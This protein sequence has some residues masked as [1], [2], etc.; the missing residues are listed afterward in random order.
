MKAGLIAASIC[1]ASVYL[2]PIARAVD[3]ATQTPAPSKVKV[4]LI[5]PE[6]SDRDFMCEAGRVQSV[7]AT[8]LADHRVVSVVFLDQSKEPIPD[9]VWSSAYGFRLAHRQN[10]KVRAALICGN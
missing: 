9:G 2:C 1:A 3:D 8:A 6:E 4:L 5:E 10:I 7:L